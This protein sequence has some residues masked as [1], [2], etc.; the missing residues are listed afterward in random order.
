[1][2][3]GQA[4]IDE[5]DLPGLSEIQL[6]LVIFTVRKGCGLFPYEEE[7]S[8]AFDVSPVALDRLSRINVAN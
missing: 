7:A 2:R 6:L 1:M 3:R 5:A 8:A 4:T